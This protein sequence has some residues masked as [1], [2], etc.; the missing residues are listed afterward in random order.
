[1]YEY[2][3][4]EKRE[5]R[6]DQ[7]NTRNYHR[8]HHGNMPCY[9]IASPELQKKLK[10]Y[11]ADRPRRLKNDADI[12]RRIIAMSEWMDEQAARRSRYANDTF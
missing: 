9:S 1:M 4:Q 2:D 8:K 10:E 5:R 6:R 12:K 7:I 3:E 11:H